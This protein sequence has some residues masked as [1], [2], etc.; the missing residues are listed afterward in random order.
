MPFLTKHLSALFGHAL[1]ERVVVERP[2]CQIRLPLPYIF[3]QSHSPNINGQAAI[4]PDEERNLL[5]RDWKTGE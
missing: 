5:A 3:H 2:V 4:T 1:I